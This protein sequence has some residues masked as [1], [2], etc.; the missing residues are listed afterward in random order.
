MRKNRRSFSAPISPRGAHSYPLLA[1]MPPA[2]R[3]PSLPPTAATSTQEKDLLNRRF[4][5]VGMRSVLT[6]AVDGVRS[7][8]IEQDNTD[9]AKDLQITTFIAVRAMQSVFYWIL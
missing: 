3:Q 7:R 9:Y 2:L 1:E 8:A 6:T 5:P 4:H